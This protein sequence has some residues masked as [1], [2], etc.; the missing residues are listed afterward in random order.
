MPYLQKSGGPLAAAT[1]LTSQMRLVVEDVDDH[2]AWLLPVSAL[3][4]GSLASLESVNNSNWSGT[5]L[6]V[7]NGGT[8]ASDASTARTNL[9]LGSLATASSVSDASWSGTDLAVANGG[10]GASDAATA[11]TNLGVATVGVSVVL[12]GGGSALTTSNAADIEIPF[13]ATIT[14]ARAFADVSGSITVTIK[15]AASGAFPP[16]SSI[17]ASAPVVISSS[18]SG[19]SALTGWTTSLAAA[20]TLRF[21][22]S[23]ITS[24]TRLTVALTLTRA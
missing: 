23:S 4:L 3:G 13:A 5:D 7:A 6:A 8:G 2:E 11:R 9:G 20:D 17:V 16:S 10:T 22:L 18:T 15:R 21:E 14:A 19:S 24:I 1:D 12:D